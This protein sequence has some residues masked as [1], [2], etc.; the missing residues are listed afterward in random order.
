MATLNEIQD[1]LN[2]KNF[3][4]A[5]VSRD[6]KKF[7]HQVFKDLKKKGYH[8]Y[9]INPNTDVIDEE[10]CYRDISE[11]PKEVTH[12]LVLT[13]KNQTADVLKKAAEKGIKNVWIQQMSDTPDCNTIANENNMSLIT[14]EC[15]HMFAEPVEGFHRFHRGVKKIFG[16]Y[17]KAVTK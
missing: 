1:F 9:P 13:P 3:A 4:I 16:R 11:L 12:L 8:L 6:P 14:G 10:K 17:P 5:G 2:G 7:G 15:I